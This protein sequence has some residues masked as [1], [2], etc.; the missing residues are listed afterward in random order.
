[1]SLRYDGQGVLEYSEPSGPLHQA[2]AY[3]IRD[4]RTA[5]IEIIR[6]SCD[7]DSAAKLSYQRPLTALSSLD[8]LPKS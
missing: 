8:V 4:D 6:R 5:P 3:K 2:I 7:R 1:M